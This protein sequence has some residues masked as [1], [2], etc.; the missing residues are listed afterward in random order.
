MAN[1]FDFKKLRRLINIYAVV[2][3]VLIGLLIYV[4]IVFQAGLQAE[5]RAPRF[6]HSV[7][8]TLVIQLAL[9]FPIN[10]FARREAKREV[11]A[12]A[13]GLTPEELKSQR[14]KRLFGDVI[15]MSVFIFF[16]TF[17][18]RAPKDRFFLSIVFFS[19]ILTILSYFQCFNFAAKREMQSRQ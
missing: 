7:I 18:Y 6:L 8:A 17:V 3:V 9:F 16:A 4:A 11:D 19:F 12:L 10:K 15:K 2:Q 13:P 1:S 5:G 14:N